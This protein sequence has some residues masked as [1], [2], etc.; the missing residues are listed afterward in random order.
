M[1]VNAAASDLLP[2]LEKDK[3]TIRSISG[4]AIVCLAA[5][6]AI[7]ATSPAQA[8]ASAGKSPDR[9]IVKVITK[10]GKITYTDRSVDT[11]PN[12]QIQTLRAGVGNRI[13]ATLPESAASAASGAAQS[14]KTAGAAADIAS[15]AQQQEAR[16]KEQAR[17]IKEANAAISA[18]N[19]QSARRNLS[20]IEGKK[21]RLGETGADGKFNYY[22]DD[23]IKAK[24][25]EASAQIAEFCK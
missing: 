2:S 11:K 9:A 22:S 20:A 19:C 1:A 23:Q 8:Q 7:T 18:T 21:S 25:A 10:D 14:G 16:L 3:M 24:Q 12:T 5:I 17:Q 4:R 6:A 15:L 13:L